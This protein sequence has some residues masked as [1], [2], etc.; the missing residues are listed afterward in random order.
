[1]KKLLLVLTILGLVGPATGLSQYIETYKYKGLCVGTN[2][3]SDGSNSYAMPFV[4]QIPGGYRMY[5]TADNGSMQNL[6]TCV[7]YAE[8]PDG[9]AWTVKGTCIWGST[10]T[11]ARN[12][13]MGGA[14]VLKLPDGRYRM[15]YRTCPKYVP[16]H[17]PKYQ[18]WSAISTD[19]GITFTNEGVCIDIQTYNPNSPFVL[20]GHGFA[21]KASNGKYAYIFSGNPVSN[22]NSPSDLWLATSTDGLNWG[23]YTKLFEDFHDPTVIYKDGKYMLYAGYLRAYNGRAVSSDGITWP[24]AMDSIGFVNANNAPMSINTYGIGDLGACVSWDN[25]ILMYSNFINGQTPAIAV[26]NYNQS[27]SGGSGGGGSQVCAAS[28]SNGQTYTQNFNTLPASGSATA[29]GALPCGWYATRTGTGT[30]IAAS[31]GWAP[32]GNLYSFGANGSTDRALGSLGNEDPGAGDFYWG[33]LVKNTGTTPITSLSISYVAEQ[34]RRGGSNQPQPVSFA[35]KTLT[36]AST[37]LNDGG[38]TVAGNLGYTPP[39]SLGSVSGLDGS[40][41]PNRV[42]VSGVLNVS[43]PAGGFALL[44]W[45]DVNHAGQDNASGIDD[46]N[47]TAIQNC[48]TPSN[49]SVSNISTTNALVSWTLV[50]GASSYKVQ[51]RVLG[52]QT[53]TVTANLPGPSLQLTGLQPSTSYEVQVI[54][55]CGATLSNPSSSITFTTAANITGCNTPAG[56]TASVV[57]NGTVTFNWTA[58][59]NPSPVCYGVRIVGPSFN[60]E[61]YVPHPQHS[62]NLSGLNPSGNYIARIRANCT[63]C[64]A[65][66]QVSSYSAATAFTPTLSKAANVSE[67]S[68]PEFSTVLYPNPTTGFC[69]LVVADNEPAP[70]SVRLTDVLGRTLE[71]RVSEGEQTEEEILFDMTNRPEGAYIIILEKKGFL[72]SEKLIKTR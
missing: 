50:S 20:A 61:F 51:R 40:Q 39:Q 58:S 17:I 52:S 41:T 27:G 14:S 15:Y 2:V 3:S 60:Q 71:T 35:Y 33:V 10:D 55:T 57:G 5:Y 42:S 26:F 12:Y 44:R 31:D 23:N 54:G 69:R 47:V 72:Q 6:R 43:I 4:I 19:G 48:A 1:M 65:S 64:G 59:M 11:A 21:Y 68:A 36:A 66:G 45:S 32:A 22:P 34:W 56:F 18:I 28:I 38:W 13:I 30:N 70:F 29:S 62:L 24:A 25:E 67:T 8:S 9:Y 46:V 37:T 49:V 53:W 16:N 63:A 7:R